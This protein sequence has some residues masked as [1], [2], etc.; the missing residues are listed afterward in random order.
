MTR[1][2]FT[3]GGC[4]FCHEPSTLDLDDATAVVVLAW[5]A[6]PRMQRPYAQVALPF[7]SAGEREQLISGAHEACFDAAMGSDE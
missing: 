5:L 4:P 1:A 3:V 2:R 6:M 7:L